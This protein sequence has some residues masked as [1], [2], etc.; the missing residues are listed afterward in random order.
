[1]QENLQKNNYTD[2]IEKCLD[3]IIPRLN[4]K[5]C[6][7][8]GCGVGKPVNFMNALYLRAKKDPDIE[9]TIIS[10]LTLEKP[11]GRNDL[12]K[13]LL[14]PMMSRIFG[15]WPDF[16]HVTDLRNNRLPD[17]V[18]LYEWMLP[19]GGFVMHD[20]AQRLHVAGNFSIS[21]RDIIDKDINLLCHLGNSAEINGKKVITTGGNSDVISP[22]IDWMLEQRPKTERIIMAE[23]NSNVP[24]LWGE[25][26]YEPDMY[27]YILESDAFNQMTF[28]PPKESI[29]NTDHM[30]GFYSSLLVKDGGTL[31]IGIGSMGDA[32]TYGILM[33]HRHNDVFSKLM[34]KS[35]ILSQKANLIK[36]FGGHTPFTDGLFCDS[37]MFVDSYLDL[38]DAGILS[39]K[40]Y[41][42]YHIQKLINEKRITEEI[43]SNTIRELL[44]AGAIGTPL[45]QNEFDYLVK[46][47]IL[48][49]SV[50]YSKDFLTYEGNKIS[51]DIEEVIAK[52]SI[53]DLLGEKLTGGEVIHATLMIAPKKFYQRINEMP[54]DEKKLFALKN[55]EFVNTLNGEEDLKAQQRKEARF[56]NFSLVTTVTGAAASETIKNQQ[57]I[58]GIGGQLDFVIMANALEDARSILVLNSTRGDGKEVQSNIVFEYTG[59]SVP[60]QLRD[61]IV[62]EYGIADLRGCSDEECIIEMIKIADSRFQEELLAEAKKYK[63]VAKD[64]VLPEEYRNN[65]PVKIAQYLE[66]FK[67]DGFYGAFPFGGDVTEEEFILG[68]SLKNFATLAR[69]NKIKTM[70]GVMLKLFKKPEAKH[71]KYIERMSL[72]KVS[73]FSERFQRAVVMTALDKKKEN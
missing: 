71:R 41:D 70:T 37:E 52:G 16:E 4:K 38:Y 47:G 40:V 50:T 30:I 73:N 18:K 17:N 9:L 39:R 27:D 5:I 7:G 67:K 12:E 14:D 11:K 58:S 48:K 72:E 32:I 60:R 43:T 56:I 28:C 59:C 34:K 21:P 51:T 63:K 55:I 65:T 2:N 49:D 8:I 42:D 62:T 10:A 54:L 1:M 31:Q 68:S 45:R 22:L 61:I 46:H 23:L 53:D 66:E 6:V 24:F 33:R 15:D 35:D 69:D 44:N 3:E 26:T 20:T 29:S 25:T 57:V 19:P 36:K 64:F 13:R